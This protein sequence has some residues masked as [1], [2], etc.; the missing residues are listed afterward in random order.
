MGLCGSKTSARDSDGASVQHK[1]G[2]G[3]PGGPGV[4]SAWDVQVKLGSPH[5]GG[6]DHQ[7]LLGGDS[8]GGPSGATSTPVQAFAEHESA[9][10]PEGGGGGGLTSRFFKRG[11]AQPVQ[12]QPLRP[13]GSSGDAATAAGAAGAAPLL[14]GSAAAVA[15]AAAAAS[16]AAAAAVAAAAATAAAAASGGTP[17]AAGASA[18]AWR[19]GGVGGAAVARC[20]AV[21]QTDASLLYPLLRDPSPTVPVRWRKGE[22][23]GSGSFGQVYLALNCD[24]GELLAVKEVPAGLAGGDGGGAGGG[25]REAVAQLE[26]EVALLSALR[27][28]N[29]VRYVGTQR[30]AAGGGGAGG[31]G[32]GAPLYIFLEYVPGGSLSSQ[33]ARFGPLPEP[34]VALYT[35]QLLLGLAYLHA[36]RTVHRDVKGANLLLEK[37]G[38]L[39]LADFGMA[40]QLMEQV[41]FT[42]S[43]KGS[44]Y[45]MAPEVIKQQGYGVQADIWSVGCTVLEMATGKPPWSQ[46]TS[47]VQAIFKIA[48][49][50]D[51]PAIPDHLSP[52]ASEFILL[53]LQRDPSARPT[54]EELLRHPFVT[55][56]LTRIP[57]PPALA[58]PLNFLYD[59]R[60]P[61]AGL[62]GGG[63]GALVM[64]GGGGGGGGGG[65][66]GG[67]GSVAAGLVGPGATGNSL[68]LAM[69][70]SP[71]RMPGH[72]GMVAAG[73]GRL[74]SAVGTPS[75]LGGGGGGAGGLMLSPAAAAAAAA[76]HAAAVNSPAGGGGGPAANPFALALAAAAGAPGLAGAGGAG[77]GGA[78]GLD[79]FGGG[80]AGGGGG[81]GGPLDEDHL[82][83]LV[84]GNSV[85]ISKAAR[86]AQQA[87][88]ADEER[89][90]DDALNIDF[91][92]QPQQ[93][94]VRGLL[95]LPPLKQLTGGQLPPLSVSPH[96]IRQQQPLAQLQ[97]QHGSH[98][99]AMPAGAYG[100]GAYGMTAEAAAAAAGAAL[101]FAGGIGGVGG[102]AG[103]GGG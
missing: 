29:I 83:A 55:Q 81:G 34:L 42:R 77:G 65:M 28:P 48:S 36:Q 24:T 22:G 68:A 13:G 5:G 80:G 18:V 100:A 71:L 1:D 64:A 95:T 37:T 21:A 91:T 54:A 9:S 92:T 63:G 6:S 82:A 96:M 88:A 73:G 40:K 60:G 62:G 56:P 87:M 19:S 27:H 11:A 38:V 70:L 97:Q 3:G 94:R 52:Q 15:A 47:Q 43:F 59:A 25:G 66:G 58:D 69:G 23:I 35:R 90:E 46:C 41:S 4:A 39:K 67:T 53:C 74:G 78:A 32:G 12:P 61:A 93:F 2:A 45:W 16:G 50:P 44:A 89:E 14:P 86:A 33:L 49:S 75:A 79:F 102:A 8:A 98:A 7:P 31:G 26:R 30:N 57:L 51:L 76:A 103:G 84:L 20:D 99:S 10:V 101:S 72:A 85:H 17:N